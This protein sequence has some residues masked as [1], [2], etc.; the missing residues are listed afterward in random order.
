MS[1]QPNPLLWSFGLGTWAGVR[2]RV[3]W[4]QPVIWFWLWHLFDDVAMASAVFFALFASVLLH[5]IG[6]VV[7]ARRTGGT[8]DEIVIWPLGGLA[9]V[10]Y[11]PGPMSRFFTAAA[12]PFV[13]LMLLLA[14]LPYTLVWAARPETP[15]AAASSAVVSS[16]PAA[17]TSSTT[18]S[19]TVKTDSAQ[20]PVQRP[21]P[22][23]PLVLPVSKLGT[24]WVGELQVIVF[25][26]NWMLLL[27]NLLPIS[28]LDGYNMTR[29]VMEA[30]S[31]RLEAAEVMPKVGL[32]GA[33][34]MVVTTSLFL[35]D[36][37]LTGLFAFLGM[38]S[39]IEYARPRWSEGEE[40]GFLGYDFSE[41]YTSLERSA[42]DD[43]ESGSQAGRA[44]PP[45][46]S[47]GMWQKWKENREAERERREREQ[48][49]LEQTKL[50]DL[51]AKV[52]ERG[53][54]GLSD[55]EKRELRQLSERLRSRGK[56]N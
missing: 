40:E 46:N 37:T 35:K 1:S 31:G 38:L 17:T 30:T 55:G 21:S 8:A 22:W 49:E 4:L 12:G 20:A 10:T 48:V 2:V 11:G 14:C 26:L 16:A 53:M 9:G 47:P 42:E 34:A 32:I 7:A 52:H 45:E 28:P 43:D 19:T 29:G 15:P 56:A 36:T 41:G 50:D 27:L 24:D 3:S 54:D 33:V 18:V 23:Y 51:L 39:A 13:N 6:H 25:S 5:E 44:R